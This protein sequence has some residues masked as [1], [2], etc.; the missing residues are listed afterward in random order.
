MSPATRRPSTVSSLE[1]T[2]FLKQHGVRQCDAA[3]LL[4]VSVATMRRYMKG[5]IAMR[6]NDWLLIKA[7]YGKRS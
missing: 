7:A 4:G 6:K 5:E 1:L 3:E 2:R